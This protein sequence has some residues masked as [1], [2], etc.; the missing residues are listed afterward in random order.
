MTSVLRDP[1]VAMVIALLVVLPV[2]VIAAGEAE[3]RLRQRDSAF[4]PVL[5]VLRWWT[6]PLTALWFILRS[7]V[8]LPDTG[9]LVRV[10]ATGML[11]SLAVA[12]LL[13]TRL[14]IAR[15]KRRRG[16]DRRGQLPQIVLALPRLAITLV[17]GWLLL[18][19]VWG[20]DLSAALTALGVG[21]LVVSFALQDTLSGLASGLLMLA[22]APFAP[23]DWI[24]HGEVEGRVVDLSWRSTRIESRDG[25][26]I[27][28]PNAE[29]AAAMLVNF[30]RP[31]RLHRVVVPVQVAY[32]NPP[33]RARDM[34]LDAARATPDVLTD[35]APNVR[36]VQIDD[37]LMGYEVDLWIDDFRIAP[38]VSSEFGALVWYHSHRHDV[39][40]PS[41]AYDLYVYDGVAAS[42]SARP[43]APTIQRRL[44]S[45]PL[46]DQ[47]DD[48]AIEHL[49]SAATAGRFARDETIVTG[50]PDRSDLVVLWDGRARLV[51]VDAEGAA[52][53]IGQFGP[54][55]VF[56]LL[57]RRGAGT[58]TARVDAIT[59]CEVIVVDSG[60]AAE[61][62][63]RNP[64]LSEALEQLLASQQRRIERAAA[65]P[66]RRTAATNGQ[67]PDEPD[68]P[69]TS[70]AD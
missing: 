52:A 1:I 15:L 6:L 30:D 3:E 28:V 46:L 61:V 35:P 26:L 68:V 40:L 22:D 58:R 18:D 57:G 53:E 25:D 48:P 29:L 7:V 37:P 44:R 59:D 16:T 38:R 41:P 36:V 67:Q 60:R 23:G 33:S 8:G 49:E 14:V 32:A 12:A 9:P 34:L 20:V 54:G 43:D 39:P 19:T 42:A 55:D 21:T 2:A 66:A 5:S 13:A 50:D 27:I 56:G 62:I 47:L 11:L 65:M 70:G 24:R 31:G 10:V 45:S 51:A 69:T 4:R 64:E 63:S 17:I